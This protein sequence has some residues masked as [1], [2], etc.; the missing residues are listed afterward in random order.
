MQNIAE[1]F[2]L[3]LRIIH[4]DFRISPMEPSILKI[5]H[6]ISFLMKIDY[7]R[8]ALYIQVCLCVGKTGKQ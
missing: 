1:V 5:L 7:L 6:W 8:T 4:T 2:I 3:L